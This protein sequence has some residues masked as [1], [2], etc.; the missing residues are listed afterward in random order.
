MERIYQPSRSSFV[1]WREMKARFLKTRCRCKNTFVSYSYSLK[2]WRQF[3]RKFDENLDPVLGEYLPLRQAIEAWVWDMTSTVK[4]VTALARLSAVKSFYDWLVTEYRLMDNN[5]ARML[6]TSNLDTP[7]VLRVPTS[8]SV[9]ALLADIEASV[10]VVGRRDYIVVRFLRESGVRI[11]ELVALRVADLDGE[12]HI[13][14]TSGKGNKSRVTAVTVETME[15]AFGFVADNSLE[16]DDYLFMPLRYYGWDVERRRLKTKGA[17]AI[18]VRCVRLMLKT[19]AIAAGF[20]PDVV[21]ILQS[22]H[23]YRHLWTAEHVRAGTDSLILMRM[24]GWT[25]LQMIDYYMGQ[26][27]VNVHAVRR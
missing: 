21:K 22:P 6:T 7:R 14:V 4:E 17:K 13:K 3:L 16:A 20:E 27:G 18:D 8:E 23:N 11:S 2:K 12:G 15:L 10:D 9:D 19:R 5:P 1:N 26:E 25:N 24:G